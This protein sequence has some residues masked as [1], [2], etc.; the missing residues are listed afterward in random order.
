[1]A[2]IRK[3]GKVK[4]MYF[5]M[6]SSAGAM[7]VGTLMKLASGVLAVADNAVASYNIVGVLK[8]AITTAD[9]DYALARLVAIE[10][11]VEKNVVYEAPVNVGTL[12]TTS[13]GLYFDLSTDD[14]GLSV[15]Q[16]ASALDICLCTKFKTT[17]LGEFILNI[18]PDAST[19]A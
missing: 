6:A 9:A 19:K 3:Q 1:M 8:K 15:D 12:A 7:A 4:I 2:F 13:V 17:V 10:V 16:S 18:G 5:P 14:L 11:P